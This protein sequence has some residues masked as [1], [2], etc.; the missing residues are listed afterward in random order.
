MP[1]PPP[2]SL[3]GRPVWERLVLQVPPRC[4]RCVERL[5]HEWGSGVDYVPPNSARWR[6]RDP[7]GTISLWCDPCAQPLRQFDKARGEQA[8]IDGW[9]KLHSRR[10]RKSA[11]RH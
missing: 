10:P 8:K 1:A 2:P 5:H 7:D 6:R 3:P 4:G 11:N 9:N